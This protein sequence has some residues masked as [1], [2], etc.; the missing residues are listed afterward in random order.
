MVY[1]I[2]GAKS[3]DV[4]KASRASGGA[5][6]DQRLSCLFQPKNKHC[7]KVLLCM[8]IFLLILF[9]IGMDIYKK[10]Q[11]RK[12]VTSDTNEEI[13][14]GGE[15]GFSNIS[16]ISLRG[17][18]EPSRYT[19]CYID[20]CCITCKR[21]EADNMN[22]LIE[23][24]IRKSKGC[25]SFKLLI[26]NLYTRNN[27]LYQ[28]WLDLGKDVNFESLEIQNSRV[29]QIREYSF[30]M[31]S[32][33]QT[34]VLTLDRLDITEL[35]SHMF[36]GLM[37]LQELR[38]KSLP[39]MLIEQSVLHPL[40]YN[41]QTLLVERSL[42]GV[43]PQAFTGS[44]LM[45]QLNNISLR[46]N[47]FGNVIEDDAFQMTPWLK[48]LDLSESRIVKLSKGL[49]DRLSRTF[50]KHLHLENNLLTTISNNTFE[51]L[52]GM[53]VKVYL[54]GNP[55]KCDCSLLYL[56][57][58]ILS[59]PQ[60][61]DEIVCF[62]PNELTGDLVSE[63]WFCPTTTTISTISTTVETTSTSRSTRNPGKPPTPDATKPTDRPSTPPATDFPSLEPCSTTPPS[64]SSTHPYT[65]FK[66]PQLYSMQ[67][68]STGLPVDTDMAPYYGSQLEI[69]R[70]T[71]VFSIT[72]AQLG[73]VEIVLDKPYP[74]STIIWFHDPAPKGVV[75]AVNLEKAAHCV[76]I[77]GRSIRINNL[78]PD[79]NYIFCVFP[80][81]ASSISPFD[82]LPFRL[83][84]ASK[85]RTWMVE[86]DK[87]MM[88]SVMISSV[89][90][91]V[92][93]GVVFMYCF[94]KTFPSH[95]K[96][97]R[98]PAPRLSIENTATNQC[99]MT[100]PA[101]P[102]APRMSHPSVLSRSKRSASDTSLE[103]CRSSRPSATAPTSKIQFITWRMEEH[104][105]PAASK[106]CCK[107]SFHHQYHQQS[108]R[109]EHEL[110]TS[111]E[112][113]VFDTCHQG[114]CCQH[115]F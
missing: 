57:D 84:P 39:L 50:L 68:L 31:S 108:D 59:Q 42:F 58:K 88:I 26:E 12:L 100:P 104:H 86:D 10:Y 49:I 5:A 45:F 30:E 82:C 13:V 65:T 51:R 8:I 11:A 66:P 103:S 15:E 22:I 83:L 91:A 87:I 78:Q 19:G 48:R 23:Q 14:D 73:A 17:S 27:A 38:L 105:Y 20:S 96:N 90:I 34:L 70:R 80:R 29:S 89:L 9:W 93:T 85:Q 1:Q 63:A 110:T 54:K 69:M 7:I 74:N 53:H 61:F 81:N 114:K 40:R 95:P 43:S 75:F 67:C 41:L 62:E 55:F 113:L 99:Y 72:D 97:H 37:Q 36:T 76:D 52:S 115:D 3:F 77:F 107:G 60:M 6:S 71:K 33:S 16:A 44:I 4:F 32:C 111:E 46:H 47:N 25:I 106:P 112:G 64:V 35:R 56:K 94:N 24:L 18:K 101:A 21:M 2:R 92:L 109:Q 28:G 102:S 79:R 98:L